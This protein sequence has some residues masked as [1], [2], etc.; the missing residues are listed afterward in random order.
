MGG[1]SLL[2]ASDAYKQ[3][4][5]L[6]W[7]LARAGFVVATGGGPG[8]MEA[9]NLGAYMFKR[10]HE[11]LLEALAIIG[12][13]KPERSNEPEYKNLAAPRAVLARFG[14]TTNAP[15]LGIPTWKYGHEPPNLFATYQAK[16]FSNA[17]REVGTCAEPDRSIGST[18]D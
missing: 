14:A 12:S 5:L 2:R 8:A 18:L 3:V 4:A 9:G 11:E 7:K 6:G 13:V 15:S 17:V 16:M 1:H 10:S